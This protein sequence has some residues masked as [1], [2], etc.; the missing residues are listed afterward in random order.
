M[1]GLSIRMDGTLSA[2]GG[3]ESRVGASRSNN[4]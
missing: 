3:F 4:V 1:P 2:V